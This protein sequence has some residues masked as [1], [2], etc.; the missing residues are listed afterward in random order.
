LA[1]DNLI[2]FV[3]ETDSP[4]STTTSEVVEYAP[5]I[6]YLSKRELEVIEA[7]LAGNLSYKELSFALNVSVNTVKTHLKHI[8]KT[9]GVSSIAA[10]SSLFRGFTTPAQL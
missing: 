7:V 2:T 4:P 8:Y 1:S 3:K 10:L 6:Q 5:F 9:T